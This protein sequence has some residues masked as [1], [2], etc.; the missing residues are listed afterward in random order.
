MFRPWLRVA[1]PD[2]WTGT[3]AR[4]GLWPL[5]FVALLVVGI[6][7]IPTAWWVIGASSE[8]VIRIVLGLAVIYVLGWVRMIVWALVPG[9]VVQ[10]GRRLWYRHRGRRIR[11]MIPNISSIDVEQRPP[12][13]GEVFVLEIG[14]ATHE[15]CPVDWDGAVRIYAVVARRVRRTRDRAARRDARAR[16]RNERA[17]AGTNK[18]GSLDLPPDLSQAPAV[19]EHADQ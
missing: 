7:R 8:A 14:E 15:L 13:I 16:R 6:V 9:A 18:L 12:P 4:F 17:S 2:D 1:R 19:N 11:V 3:L 10:Y 5:Y